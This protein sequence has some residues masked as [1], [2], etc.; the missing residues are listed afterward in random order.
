[1]RGRAKLTRAPSPGSAAVPVCARVHHDPRFGQRRTQT[2]VA[3]E[4]T[5]ARAATQALPA[6]S[7]PHGSAQSSAAAAPY[8]LPA[9]D[10]ACP[11]RRGGVAQMAALGWGFS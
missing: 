10:V 11:Q 5:H 6:P 3:G 9:C 1:M 7:A 2:G 4:G 8:G